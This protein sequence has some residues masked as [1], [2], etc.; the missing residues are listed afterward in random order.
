MSSLDQ[1]DYRF[2]W[3]NAQ[4]A[5]ALGIPNMAHLEQPI[6]IWSYIRIANDI[7]RQVP[8]GRLLDWGCGCGQ[9]AY[10]LERRGFTV[11]P[12]D[13]GP[14]DAALPDLPLCR[15]LSVVRTE[16]R[17]TLPFASAS[18]DAVLSC[19]V[20]EHVEAESEPGN[21]RRSLAEIVRVLRPG[22]VFLIYQLPQEHAWQEAVIRR[23]RLGYAHPRRY[24]A[25]EIT[26]ILEGAGFRVLQLRRANLIPRNLTGMPE[27]LRSLYSRFSL[28]LIALDGLLCR[29][30]GLNQVAGVLEITAQTAHPSGGS[31]M[32]SGSRTGSCSL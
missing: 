27:W 11:V 25:R 4:A 8:P 19:G 23:W 14:P 31:D 17:T 2:L 22:G 5:K 18:F 29:L 13:I 6:G 32:A 20:L 21:E 24:T 12:F 7:R 16:D 28:P 1:A 26:A 10:L 3:A 9:M 30:P 15:L